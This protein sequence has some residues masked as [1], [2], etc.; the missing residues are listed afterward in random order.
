MVFAGALRFYLAQATEQFALDF[1]RQNLF[2][3]NSI[4]TLKLTARLNALADSLNWVCIEASHG[5]RNFFERRNGQCETGLIKQRADI[6]VPQ[7]DDLR[8]TFTLRLPQA[9]EVGALLFFTLQGLLLITLISVSK[10][11][12]RRLV[13]AEKA[14]VDLATQTAHDLRS[15]LSALQ[16]LSGQ[17]KGETSEL[18]GQFK[19]IAQRIERIAEDL[20]ATAKSVG[21][22]RAVKTQPNPM[23][24]V[25]D[26]K[27]IIDTIVSE[28]KLNYSES[29]RLRIEAITPQVSAYG[30]IDSTE[31][32]RALSNLVENSF[33]AIVS[34]GG[35]VR[36]LLEEAGSEWHLLV[37]D[38]GPG[39]PGEI[40]G[41]IGNRGATFGKGEGAQGGLGLG[42]FHAKSTLERAGGRLEI[43]SRPNEGTT[44]RLCIPASRSLTV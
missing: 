37:I 21:G 7:A 9:L 26:L 15:P 34:R 1:Q 32:A 19:T 36:I 17:L 20:V 5:G 43:R 39:I 22:F 29:A 10:N 2:E 33:E 4:D 14:L 41:E 31:L 25:A 24:S 13:K 35:F 12:E 3:I 8:I 23:T 16:L 42:L 30:Q 38:N 28:K 44:I 18:G 27:R 6:F 40:L 11:E